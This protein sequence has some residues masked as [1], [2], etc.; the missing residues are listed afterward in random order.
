[1]SEQKLRVLF[2][3]SGLNRVVRGAEV[4]FE[5][6]AGAL[7]RSG[8]YDVTVM[9]SGQARPGDRYRFRHVACRPREHFETWPK[10]PVLRSDGHYEELT[11]LAGFAR[12]YRPTDFDVTVTCTYPF[13]NW[14][15]R[16]RR[17]RGRHP[18]NLFVT[19]N[20]DWPLYRKNSEFRF[21]HCDGLVCTNPDYFDAH[22]A[23]WPSVLIPNGVDCSLF[24]PGPAQRAKFGLPE[25]ARIVLMVSALIPTK[26][27]LEGIRAT[28]AVPDAVLLVAGDG[29][30]RDE[31]DALGASLLGERFQRRRIARADMPDLY[32][33]ADVFLHM[34]MDEP[35]ANAYI[36]AL[37]SGL[38]IVTHRRRVTEWTLG[39]HALL[40][41]ATDL[42]AVAQA[43]RTALDARG[44]R[45]DSV[46][47]ARRRYDWNNIAREYSGFIKAR[48]A[49]RSMSV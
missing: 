15:V 45:L 8:D 26:R 25:G 11:F 22:R 42:G 38:P 3:L 19:Q 31:V 28:A 43:V 35:S 16:A 37:A 4:A 10:V 6:I 32:R 30:L 44:H 20:G 29:P 7:A 1:M 2:A 47:E 39:K 5:S 36:E 9:G 49:A 40:V 21:F 24:N 41:D 46:E 27:V 14:F 48:L 12:E 33:S 17:H 23:A 13:L 18:L 34:S